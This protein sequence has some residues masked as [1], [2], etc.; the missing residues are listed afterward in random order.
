MRQKFHF[1]LFNAL[2]GAIFGA[3]VGYYIFHLGISIFTG[4]L[5]GLLL[6]LVV[7]LLFSRLNAEHW[8]YQRRVL[9]FVLLEIPLAAFVVGPYAYVYAN[10]LPDQHPICC[11]T[12]LDYGA[13]EYEDI[14]IQT[15]DG[16]ILAGW[17]VPPEEIPGAIIVLLHGAHGD[18]TGTAWHARQLI[19]AGYGVLLYDQRA[20][21]ESDGEVVAM[22]W[23]EGPD[24]LAVLNYLE[25]RPEVDATQIGIVGL[26]G[27]GHIAINAAYLAPERFHALWL[28]GIQAQQIAD[29]PEAE[30]LGEK[31]ATAINA[32]ILKMAEIYFQR[33]AP[34]PFVEILPELSEI[35]MVIIAGGLDDFESRLSQKYATLMGPNAEIWH[36]DNAWHVGGP[37]VTPEEYSQRMLAFF[38]KVFH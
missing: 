3:L 12:P 38:E 5:I 30:N 10:S 26:S 28:D 14:H 35:P 23:V 8:L 6:G 13:T 2:V 1:P 36:I 29:F 11:E 22:G 9:L 31:F 32:M 7:E 21:G 25:S 20:L 4:F 17:Y 24:L 33:A 18:R 27:G 37:A 16:L 15:D 34:P 19:Q